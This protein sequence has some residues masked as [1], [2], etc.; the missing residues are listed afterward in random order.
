[1]GVREFSVTDIQPYPIKLV[2]DNQGAVD[3]KGPG[4]MEVFPAFH[5]VPFSKML[6]FF[7]SDTFQVAGEYSGAVP[8]PDSH[9]G[10][11]EVGEVRPTAEGGNQ[12]VKV[13][14]RINPNGIFGVASASLVEKHEVEEEVPVEMEVDDKKEDGEKKE[15]GEEKMEGEEKKDEAPK[16]GGEDKMETEEPK[17]EGEKKE[18]K[19]EKR[20][21]TVNKTIELPV[22]SRVQGQLSFDKLQAATTSETMMAKADRDE[23]ERLNS[24]NSVE[25]YIYEIRGKICDDLEDFML[26]GDR[27]RFSRELT[28]AEDWLYEDGEFADKKTYTEKLATLRATGEAV[29][30]RRREF[31]ERPEAINQFGHAARPEGRRLVQGWRREVQ[32]PRHRRGGEGAKGNRREAGLVQQ[33]VRRCLQTGQD[34]RPPCVGLPVLPGEGVVL[35][36]GQQ[37]TQQAQA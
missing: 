30:K 12:K 1:M 33:D 29:R 16:E 21:K 18:V 26:E 37:H 22:S 20:K 25:E 15:G 7:K 4:E 17:K 36:H 5:A 34:L 35:A 8:F 19:M 31:T 10:N 28:D 14:V 32:P 9:I 2:W 27:E 3:E 23:A 24:K 13:K 11:F 6:T